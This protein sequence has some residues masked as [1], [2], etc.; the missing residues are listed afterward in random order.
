MNVGKNEQSCYLGGSDTDV[1]EGVARVIETASKLA[2]PRWL[3]IGAFLA[4]G[5]A[6]VPFDVTL[7]HWFLA[8]GLPGEIRALF[9]RGEVFGHGYGVLAIALTIYLICPAQRRQLGVTVGAFVIAGLLAN[10][11]KIQFWR[12]R[13]YAYDELHLTSDT[14]VGSIWWG[15]TSNLSQF[16]R[17]ALRSFPSGHTAGAVAFAYALGRMYP[18]ARG[19][20]FVLAL[21]CAGNRVDGGAHYLSDCCWGAALGL[22]VSTFWTD[23]MWRRLFRESQLELAPRE[24]AEPRRARAA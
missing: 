17:N 19:W 22:T 20:F 2:A 1:T 21:L 6:C 12:I 13:P 23:R 4:V 9:H 5:M 15:A 10:L 14:F 18:P 24:H 16:S 8:G 3:V 11:I 7:S